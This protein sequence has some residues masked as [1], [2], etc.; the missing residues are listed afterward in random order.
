MAKAKKSS[1]ARDAVDEAARKVQIINL[2]DPAVKAFMAR[3]AG[4]Y[5]ENNCLLLYVQK[6][7]AEQLHT[8]RGW[9]NEG[10]QVRSGERAIV[11][12][13]PRVREVKNADGD[14]TEEKWIR[15]IA[16]FDIAQT[17]AVAD[18]TEAA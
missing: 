4:R 10:R 11:L 6:P 1:R 9:A 14:T 17:D 2:N 13:A 3:W 7:D 16:L 18:E 12:L 8:Y 15:P 5:S